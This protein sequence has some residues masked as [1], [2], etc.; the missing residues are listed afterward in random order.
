VVQV[1]LSDVKEGASP[2]IAP[3]DPA[4]NIFAMSNKLLTSAI[5]AF[6]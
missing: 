3:V 2:R 6:I 1:R 5:I 4:K